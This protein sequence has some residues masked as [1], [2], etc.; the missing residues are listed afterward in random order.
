M[1]LSV[2]KGEV[3]MFLKDKVII[4]AGYGPGLGHDMAVIA[5]QE[6]AKVVLGAR[7]EG[8]LQAAAKTITDAGE[9][10]WR[11]TDIVKNEDCLALVALAI[12]AWGGVDA[13]INNAMAGNADLIENVTMDVWRQVFDVNL[14]GTMQ[15]AQACI[16]PMKKRGEGYIVNVSS[17]AHRKPLPPLA[18]YSASKAGMEGA[19]RYLAKELG[20]YGIRVNTARMG[21]IGGPTVDQTIVAWAAAQGR[22]TDEVEQSIANDISLG[23]IPPGPD[24]ARGVL[25]L[26]SPW[27]A[28]ISGAILDINGGD[29][30][31]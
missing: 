5:A 16:E 18:A 10:V 1:E 14:F 12:D 26:A 30:M 4:I 21:Y 2:F 23:K 29:A 22:T 8:N 6:G 28:A 17:M 24:C 9:V 31:P 25:M 7:N 20:R 19:T 27:A 13:C 11:R 3:V 15:M